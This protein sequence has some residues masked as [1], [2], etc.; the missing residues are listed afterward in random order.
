MIHH[1][2]FAIAALIYRAIMTLG[3]IFLIWFA[4]ICLIGAIW[5]DKTNGLKPRCLMFAF[6]VIAIGLVILISPESARM[7]EQP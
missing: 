2:Y 7:M 1:V 6:G 4:F 5:K 3:P